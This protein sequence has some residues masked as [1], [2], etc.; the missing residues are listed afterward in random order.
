MT[1]ATNEELITVVVIDDHPFFRDGVSRGLTMSGRVRVVGEAENGRDGIDLIAAERP[2]VALVD[3]QMPDIDGIGVVRAVKRDGLGTKVLLLSA[4]TDSA[5]V[6]RALEEGASGYL[7]KDARRA[8]IVDAVQKVARG[9]TVVPPELA[10]G[11][12]DQIRL[13]AQ[14]EAP[15]LSERE[16]QVLRGF[17]EGKS[18]PTLASE[19]FVAPSTVKTHTQRLYEKLGVSDRAAAVAEAMRQGLLE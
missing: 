4:V 10:T 3:Y 5:V 1:R 15:V 14:P 9:H 19:L 11:L 13:R 6:F 8:E 18:I 16:M 12:V 17:A 7:S 2:D